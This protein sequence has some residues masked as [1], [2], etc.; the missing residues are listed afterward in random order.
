MSGSGHPLPASDEARH[1]EIPEHLERTKGQGDDS[2][3]AV[4]PGRKAVDPDGRPYAT[5]EAGPDSGSTSEFAADQAAH[6]D[7]GQSVAAK[8]SDR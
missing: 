2:K 5:E 8:E 3:A 4:Q 1:D 7:R 6:Q